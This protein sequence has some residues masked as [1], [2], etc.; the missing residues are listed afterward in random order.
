MSSSAYVRPSVSSR[1]ARPQAP[2]PTFRP[3][4]TPQQADDAD[5]DA[6]PEAPPPT[7]TWTR[8]Y[9]MVIVWQILLILGLLAFQRTYA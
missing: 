8:M 5:R 4:L 1:C 9:A 3:V 7:G 6:S 2:P